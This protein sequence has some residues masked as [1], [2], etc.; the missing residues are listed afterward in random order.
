LFLVA[1]AVV[2]DAGGSL[3]HTAIVAREYGRPA[4][5]GTRDAT[6]RLRDGQRVLVDG[7]AGRVTLIGDRPEGS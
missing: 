4:V 5:M 2:V 1:A 6:R 7:S 3:S